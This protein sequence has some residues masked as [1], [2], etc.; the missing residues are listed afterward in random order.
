MFRK[1]EE[2]VYVR[3][4][5]GDCK[6]LHDGSGNGKKE[7]LAED[8]LKRIPPAASVSF[9]RGPVDGDPVSAL[10]LGDIEHRIGFLQD[11]IE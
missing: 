7:R 6:I 4:G 1:I 10:R 9:R 3:F 5:T 2:V 8:S 11:F